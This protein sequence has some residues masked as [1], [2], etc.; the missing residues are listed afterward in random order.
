M[1]TIK[2]WRN[3]FALIFIISIILTIYFTINKT[4]KTAIV[5]GI[6][7]TVTIIGLIK[8]N[9]QF[10]YAK[11]ICDNDIL[12][13]PSEEAII[14]TFGLLLGSKVYKWGSDGIRG[15]RLTH[16]ELD[17]KY[18]HLTFGTKGDTLNI[19]LLHGITDP[20]ITKELTQKLWYE[21]GVETHISQWPDFM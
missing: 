16:I 4:L 14:S 15:A 6:I 19:Q 3:I 17:L 1:K 12:S 11:L 20:Q 8:Q 5:F 9:N 7:T 13:I 21:T 2:K 10:Y 18:I